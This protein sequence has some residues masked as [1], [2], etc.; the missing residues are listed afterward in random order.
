MAHTKTTRYPIIGNIVYH[1]PGPLQDSVV[2]PGDPGT[3]NG[4][5]FPHLDDGEIALLQKKRYLGQAIVK[6]SK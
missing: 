3:E 4:L 5:P 2:K 6:E 1:G